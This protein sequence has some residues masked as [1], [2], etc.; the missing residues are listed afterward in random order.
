MLAAL[1]PVVSPPPI[2]PP[3]VDPPPIDP[4]PI[5]PPPVDPPPSGHLSPSLMFFGDQDNMGTLATQARCAVRPGEIAVPCFAVL[6]FRMVEHWTFGMLT[7]YGN[8]ATGHTIALSTQGDAMVCFAAYGGPFAM[9]C[10]GRAPP[11][12]QWSH[13]TLEVRALDDVRVIQD[14]VPFGSPVDSGFPPAPPIAWPEANADGSGLAVTF[15]SYGTLV[16]GGANGDR[17]VF[18]GTIANA[19]WGSGIPTTEEI[20]RHVAG[21]SA[22]AVWGVNRVFGDWPMAENPTHDLSGHGHTLTLVDGGS[23]PGHSPPVLVP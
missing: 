7:S 8:Q 1:V 12:G 10:T 13:I 17:H 22:V 16:P 20:A 2:D 14:G 19:A 23:A 4:S 18:N 6:F 15:G 5:D 9:L 11:I 3:P 21:E